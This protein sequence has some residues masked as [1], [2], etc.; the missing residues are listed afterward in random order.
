M[1]EV[2][3][4]HPLK[5]LT[6]AQVPYPEQMLLDTCWLHKSLSGPASG[7]EDSSR[8]ALSLSHPHTTGLPPVSLAGCRGHPTTF[9]SWALWALGGPGPQAMITGM[10]S[11]GCQISGPPGHGQSDPDSSSWPAQPLRGPGEPGR[12]P[13]N[14]SS[15]GRAE[16]KQPEPPFDSQ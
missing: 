2:L 14:L 3:V 7:R 9:P 11:P 6:P 5:S 4:S 10:C 15:W 12:F 8:L 16:L 1:A 13:L